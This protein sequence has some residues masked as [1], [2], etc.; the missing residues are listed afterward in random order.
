MSVIGAAA[1]GILF[2]VSLWML[3]GL[4]VGS[5]DVGCAMPAVFEE[6]D[7]GGLVVYITAVW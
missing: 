4:P 3:S 1:L 5:E 7:V 6:L 2:R